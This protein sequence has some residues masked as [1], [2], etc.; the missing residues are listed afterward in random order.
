MKV[1][2][3]TLNSAK[4]DAVRTALK[5]NFGNVE[6]VAVAAKSEV[7]DQPLSD[8]E[9][10]LGALNR[11][12]EAFASVDGADL[13]I[14]LEGTVS[15]NDFGMFLLGW[16]VII[17]ATGKTGI[18]SSGAVM[19]PPKMQAHIQA[20]G[21]LGPYVQTLMADEANEIRHS[22]GTN[23]ILTDGLYTRVDEFVDAT[24]TALAPF[25]RRD[26]Y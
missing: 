14:G 10:I 1:A 9:A 26:L 23:G 2:I 15:S 21:E 16:V 6:I 20:G 19:L 3:G 25:V 22:Q 24:L 12:K 13:G 17:D 7:S 4:Q 8:N 5:K 18:G 11:A